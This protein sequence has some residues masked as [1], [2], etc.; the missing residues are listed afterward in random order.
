MRNEAGDQ[1]R[2]EVE[3]LALNDLSGWLKQQGNLKSILK[4]DIEG[5]EIDALKGASMILENDCLV[6][7]EEHGVDMDHKISRYLNDQLDMRLYFGSADGKNLHE[8][9]SY[10]E[11][12]RLKTSKRVGY[13]LFA[14]SSDFWVNRLEQL[15][16]NG[17]TR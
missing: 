6:I 9:T 2:A 11:I 4:L 1:A 15:M 13:D 3:S 12:T 8:I 17:R 16:Q 14:T 5:V 7:Y 10:D